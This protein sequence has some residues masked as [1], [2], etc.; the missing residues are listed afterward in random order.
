MKYCLPNTIFHFSKYAKLSKLLH[1]HFSTA[2]PF[3][4]IHSIKFTP[5]DD[6]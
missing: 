5:V 1:S 3:E 6:F 2:V 4:K